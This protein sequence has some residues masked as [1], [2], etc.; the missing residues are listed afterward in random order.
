MPVR[1][2]Q[3]LYAFGISNNHKDLEELIS[4]RILYYTSTLE[5]KALLVEYNI[6]T[7]YE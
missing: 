6:N 5:W 3:Q 2:D 7:D 4:E 1:F